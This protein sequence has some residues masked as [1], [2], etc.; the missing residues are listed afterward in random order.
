MLPACSSRWQPPVRP[1]PCKRAHPTRSPRCWRARRRPST[2]R[3]IARRCR[4]SSRRLPPPNAST[5]NRPSLGRYA[6][7]PWRNGAS[8][9]I[10]LVFLT[11]VNEERH[12]AEA[13]S[14]NL[15]QPRELPACVNEPARL[16]KDRREPTPDL[17]LS[18]DP[19][20]WALTITSSGGFFGW[21]AGDLGANSEGA[22]HRSGPTAKTGS[23]RAPADALQPL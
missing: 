2:A 5:S 17:N 18:A 15:P 4:C 3:T 23:T 6:G 14:S 19:H 16:E 21:G 22:V 12:Q 1:I 13:D 7:W 10:A 8:A 20:A 9:A 11:A